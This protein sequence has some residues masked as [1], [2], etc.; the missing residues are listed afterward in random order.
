[1]VQAIQHL[2]D[3]GVTDQIGLF[4]RTVAASLTDPV[5]VALLQKLAEDNGDYFVAYQIGNGAAGRDPAAAALAY[6]TGAI[7]ASAPT[8]SVERALVF[9]VARQES[10]LDPRA[11]RT[12]EAAG[13][14]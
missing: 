7:P 8:P 13:L 2:T 10:S 14:L 9:A 11:T 6:P 1:L 12:P 4:Y 3:E 5:E